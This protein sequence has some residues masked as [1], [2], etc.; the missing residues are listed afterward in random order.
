MKNYLLIISLLTFKA[1]ADVSPASEILAAKE[2]ISEMHGVGYTDLLSVVE[3]WPRLAVLGTYEDK[4][5][6]EKIRTFAKGICSDLSNT[7][8]ELALSGDE[9]KTLKKLDQLVELYNHMVEK[10][11]YSNI[12]ITSAIRTTIR[13]GIFSIMNKNPS[14]VDAAKRIIG[15]INIDR[16]ENFNFKNWLENAEIY[17]PWAKD[18]QDYINS[19]PQFPSI[20]EVTFPLMKAKDKIPNRI[21]HV[22]LL[23]HVNSFQLG[24]YQ[25][26]SEFFEVCVI[27]FWIQYVTKE[28]SPK[29]DFLEES[30]EKYRAHLESIPVHPFFGSEV[31]MRVL[32]KFWTDSTRAEGIRQLAA[33]VG[34]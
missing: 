2:A 11:G 23:D 33:S 17:D 26:E 1:E 22:K 5:E 4:D 16:S 6:A 24:I 34:E 9:E 15:R 10:G 31:S 19:L 20:L 14:N 27:P 13:A 30:D 21:S 3:K 12:V 32:Q 29:P 25:Y 8:R 28:G 18:H 7:L